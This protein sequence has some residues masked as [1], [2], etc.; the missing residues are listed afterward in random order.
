MIISRAGARCTE[1]ERRRRRRRGQGGASLAEAAASIGMFLLLGFALYDLCV[2]VI[3][4]MIQDGATKAVARAVSSATGAQSV[5][6]VRE[7][8]V[9]L[10]ETASNVVP[11]V[12]ARLE[13]QY[14]RNPLYTFKVSS[15]DY[16]QSMPG[17]V[18]IKTAMTS[19]IVFPRLP[20]LKLEDPTTAAQACEP[21]TIAPFA[22]N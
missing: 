1:L 14:N 17:F 6:Q 21:I 12:V 16:N 13:Q 4:V 22:K 5:S 19:H 2:F 15:T 18:I 8:Q 7:G 9:S 3:G 10:S 11:G 20:F